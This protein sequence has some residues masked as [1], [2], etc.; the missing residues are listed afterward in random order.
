MLSITAS[1]KP[2]GKLFGRQSKDYT[3]ATVL[4]WQNIDAFIVGPEILIFSPFA[5][6]TRP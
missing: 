4:F 1:R 6:T 2:L 3:I 5:N